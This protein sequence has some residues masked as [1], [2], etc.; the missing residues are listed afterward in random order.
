MI[1]ASF[2]SQLTFCSPQLFL[3]LFVWGHWSLLCN[4]ESDTSESDFHTHVNLILPSWAVTFPADL[5]GTHFFSISQLATVLSWFSFLFFLLPFKWCYFCNFNYNQQHVLSA[6][7][8]NFK[9]DRNSS[10][11]S[12][13]IFLKAEVGPQW[14]RERERERDWRGK[15][16]KQFALKA[17]RPF[18]ALHPMRDEASGG[19]EM[20]D[21][22]CKYGHYHIGSPHLYPHYSLSAGATMN[23][24][25]LCNLATLLMW[26]WKHRN[27][28]GTFSSECFSAFWRSIK[29]KK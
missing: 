21:A 22:P 26:I 2:S 28:C 18:L 20:I 11:L 27:S 4:T 17:S 13:L 8:V 25:I 1:A 23:P 12:V 24:L 15:R 16:E 3:L 5:L 9:Q 19:L 29:K 6:G 14:E 10:V 7:L